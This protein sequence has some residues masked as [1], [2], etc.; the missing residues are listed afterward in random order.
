MNSVDYVAPCPAGSKAPTC[1]Q[2]MESQ[3]MIRLATTVDDT[4][5]L[6]K[7]MLAEWIKELV[8]CACPACGTTVLAS[9]EMYFKTFSASREAVLLGRYCALTPST[10]GQLQ[11]A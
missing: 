2:R 9:A 10:N 1:M 6:S 8:L 7:T 3:V 11:L 5:L 4:V